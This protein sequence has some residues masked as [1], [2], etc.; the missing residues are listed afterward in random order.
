MF[1][2]HDVG[3]VDDVAGNGEHDDDSGQA[4]VPRHGN[5][6]LFGRGAYVPKQ[7]VG[8]EH[9]E[10]R[11]PKRI[12]AKVPARSLVLPIFVIPVHA[13]HAHASYVQHR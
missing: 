11:S 12:D 13:V 8:E 3:A 10:H 7:F 5:S 4:F 1:S 9:I 6:L 2:T